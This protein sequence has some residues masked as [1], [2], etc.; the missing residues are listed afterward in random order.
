MTT[1]NTVVLASGRG[2]N[3]QAILAGIADGRL[4]GLR[5]QALIVD[6][7]NSGAAELARQAGIPVRLVEYKTF[8][9]RPE[10]DAAVLK[11]LGALAPDLILTLGW[12]RILDERLVAEYRGRIVNIHPSLLPAFPGMHAQRQAAEYGVRVSGATVHFVDAGVD[13]GPIILQQAVELAP[14]MSAQD[15]AAAILTV[16]HRIIVEAARLF[17]AG[18]LE[19]RGRQ[20]LIRD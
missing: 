6:R 4:Q 2:S 15:V 9:A 14:G 10:F 12:M 19:I 20:V 3:F 13:T 18:Q 16:E 17:A 11:E 5:V 7:P 1:T 8:A